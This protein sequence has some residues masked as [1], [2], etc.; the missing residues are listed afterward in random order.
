LAAEQVLHSVDQTDTVHDQD[1]QMHFF[2]FIKMHCVFQMLSWLLNKYC[3]V[4]TRPTLCMIKIVINQQM[5]R[6]PNY[7]DLVALQAS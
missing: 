1:R 7:S 5:I 3:T 2:L 6:N 4:L